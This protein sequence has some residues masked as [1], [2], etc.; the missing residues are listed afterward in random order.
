MLKNTTNSGT[1]MNY[2]QLSF[3]QRIEI[4]ALLKIG[5]LQSQIAN[6]LGVHKSTISREIKRNSGLRGYRPKQAQVLADSKRRH[7]RKHIR[8]TSCVKQRVIH[9]LNQD[10]SP[11]QISGY[12]SKND[13]IH[14][15]HETIYQDS[16][17]NNFPFVHIFLLL[18]C[19]FDKV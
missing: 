10:W 8:F 5:C 3:E 2:K 1:F 17:Y 9:Y 4:R 7:A 19:I 14:I 11:E 12:L 15:S 18:D 13:D 6:Q 16:F